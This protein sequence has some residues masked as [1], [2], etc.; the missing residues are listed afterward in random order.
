MQK[1]DP[2]LRTTNF[3]LIKIRVSDSDRALCWQVWLQCT[4]YLF[5]KGIHYTVATTSLPLVSACTQISNSNLRLYKLVPKLIW[6]QH[7]K[8][9]FFFRIILILSS[10]FFSFCSHVYIVH[11]ESI[12]SFSSHYIVTDEPPPPPTFYTIQIFRCNQLCVVCLQNIQGRRSIHRFHSLWLLNQ[13]YWYF[14]C[15]KFK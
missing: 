14:E 3:I 7:Q 9:T 4:S 13:R 10:V 11:C 2:T 5:Y 15:H 6:I 12:L 1:N 8:I